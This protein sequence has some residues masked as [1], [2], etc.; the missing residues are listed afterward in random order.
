MTH[1]AK[2]HD[3]FERLQRMREEIDHLMEGEAQRLAKAEHDL[4]VAR[5][6]TAAKIMRKA[7]LDVAD[8][9]AVKNVL[10]DAV[11]TLRGAA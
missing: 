1:A 11:E 7:R 5:L 10:N 8:R 3:V 9:E 4:M 2:T 6:T